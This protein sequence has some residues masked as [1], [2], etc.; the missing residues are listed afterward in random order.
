MKHVRLPA[1]DALELDRLS[2]SNGVLVNDTTNAVVRYMDGETPGGFKL[3]TQSYV[4]N[5][6]ITSG[7]LASNL[8]TA[9]QPY[10]LTSSLSVYATTTALNSAISAIPIYSLPTASTSVL[11][12]VK[13]DGTSIT[14]NNGVIS[15]SNQYTLPIATEGTIGGVRPDGTTIT[16]NPSTGVI[17]GANTYTLPTATVGTG[18]T[19]T[20]GGVKVDGSTITITNGVISGAN[21]YVLPAAS[22]TVIGGVKVAAVGTSGLTLDSVSGALSVPTASETQKGL[23]SVPAVAN[24]GLTNT[25]GAIRL[26]TATTNQLGG[27]KVDGVTITINGSG[28]IAANITGAIVFQGGWSAA[29]N[30]PTLSNVSSAY[31]TNGFEFVTTAAGTVNFGAGNVTFAVG[32]N[33]IYDGTKWVK[34][35]IGSSA[36]TTN[37]LLTVDDSGTGAVSTTTFNGSAPITISYNSIGASPLAG[38]SSLT[39][40]GTIASGTWNGGVIGAA[41]GGTGVNNT[42]TLSVTGA[43]RTLDQD[44]ASGSSPTFTATNFSGTAASLTAGNAT[45]ADSA[46]SAGKSTNV[47]G[48]LANQLPY[49]TAVDTTSFITAPT[50]AST[51]L[52]WTGSAFAWATVSTAATATNIAGGAANQIV[53]QSGSGTTTFLTAPTVTN[54]YLRWTGSAFAFSAVTGATGGTVTSVSGTGTVS[55]IT[56]T[57]TVTSSGNLTLGGTLSLVSPPAIGSTTANTGAFTIL[58]VNSGSTSAVTLSPTGSGTV[59]IAPTTAGTI[60]NMSIGATTAATGRFTTVTS[61]IATGTAPFTVTSTTNVANLNASSLNGATFGSPGAIGGTVANTGAFTTVT[62]STQAGTTNNSGSIRLSNATANRIDFVA[63]GVAAPTFTTESVGTKIVLYPALGAAAVDWAIGIDNGTTWFSVPAVSATYHWSFYGGTTEVVDIDGTGAISAKSYASTVAT[64]TAPFTVASTTNV[65]NLN[66]S[67]L[68]GATFAAPGAIGSGTASTGAFTTVTATTSIKASGTGGIGYNT[69]ASA[70]GTVTQLVSRTTG[71]TLD[72]I[73]GR[74]T[75]IS[76]AGDNTQWLS[77]T[78]TNSTV[79]ATDTVI[80]NGDVATNRYIANVSNVAAGSFEITYFSFG[81]AIDQPT[82][83]F[84]VIKGSSN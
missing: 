75:L 72:K 56:L 70:G 19:G 36:G 16:I 57:G 18:S 37:S 31:N 74:I 45:L 52:Q 40:V 68:N 1:Y 46:T 3:A 26:A 41:Y 9:L 66:A 33:V 15:G 59:T 55:G 79:A 54:T 47:A 58:T 29:T 25:A 73:T 78:V 8:A 6:T 5:N 60:N 22:S 38:S 61:T 14:I 12:G 84:S 28:V 13:V 35:P 69:G 80:V 83:N 27:V 4:Q 42:Y 11:G 64:G 23:V 2:Y 50:N 67:S 32:D 39:T 77:F 82:F 48:G 49:Q 30:T 71:V 76:A 21:T 53:V 34:I 20:L 63:S 43:N 24:S 10:A 62:A 17:S 44:V 51:F 65:A 7:N 81:T